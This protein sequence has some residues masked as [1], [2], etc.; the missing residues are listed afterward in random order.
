ML[1]IFLCFDSSIFYHTGLV[2]GIHNFSICYIYTYSL[3]ISITSLFLYSADIWVVYLINEGVGPAL[4]FTGLH[5]V[6][7]RTTD[8]TFNIYNFYNGKHL[9]TWEH[10]NIRRSGCV[11]PLVF[12]EIGRRCQGGAG[13]LWMYYPTHLAQEFRESLHRLVVYITVNLTNNQ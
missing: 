10:C 8:L 6:T 1:V 5:I 12:L 11:G 3:Q 4:N 13:V 9:L 2:P 7:I